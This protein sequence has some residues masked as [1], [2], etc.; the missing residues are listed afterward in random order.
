MEE[1]NQNSS[2]AS[3]AFS[4]CYAHGKVH[5]LCL[6]DLPLYL[7]NLYILSNYVAV[8]FHKNIKYYNNVLMYTSFSADINMIPGQGISD[9]RMHGQVYHCINSL[10]PE[11]GL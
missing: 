7:L 1:K 9:F 2:L 10:L 3:L 8:F 4:T 6:I 11:D 5:L